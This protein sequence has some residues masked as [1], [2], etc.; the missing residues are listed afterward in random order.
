MADTTT[1][2]ASYTGDEVEAL[3]VKHGK[4]GVPPSKIGLLLRDQYGIPSVQDK[5]DRSITDI[6]A[7]N[8]LTGDVPEDLFNLIKKSVDI[9]DH[10]EHN[11]NDLVTKR[12]LEHTEAKIR[13]LVRYYIENGELPGDWRYNPNTARLLVA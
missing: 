8:D 12:S 4:N 3:V 1:R 5:T 7:D 13:K 10:L 2:G 9:R 6:L 11:R